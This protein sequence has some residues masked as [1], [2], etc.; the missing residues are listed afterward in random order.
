MAITFCRFC[1]LKG[2]NPCYYSRIGFF[3]FLQRPGQIFPLFF[4]IVPTVKT[5]QKLPI[6]AIFLGKRRLVRH[7][8]CYCDA[9]WQLMRHFNSLWDTST[10]CEVRHFNSLWCTSTACEALFLWCHLGA[11]EGLWRQLPAGVSTNAHSGAV[12]YNWI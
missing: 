1:L 9:I 5:K 10:V 3:S 6:V 11:C 12:E 8:I 2:D 7:F 4:D